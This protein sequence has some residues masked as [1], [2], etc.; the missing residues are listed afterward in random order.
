MSGDT[1]RPWGSGQWADHRRYLP[2]VPPIDPAG[3]P[4]QVSVLHPVYGLDPLFDRMVTAF[5]PR[6]WIPRRPYTFADLCR[7][8]GGLAP[9]VLHPQEPAP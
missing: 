4:V 9:T 3:S 5:V 2:V 1:V 6:G 7:M 8:G